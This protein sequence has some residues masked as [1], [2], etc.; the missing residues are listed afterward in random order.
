ME[1]G[2]ADCYLHLQFYD[3]TLVYIYADDTITCCISPPRMVKQR[4]TFSFSN[5]IDL[6]TVCL[7]VYVT[8]C[9]SG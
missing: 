1:T 3:V 8:W 9:Y 6:N 7:I 4:V 2:F 5:S